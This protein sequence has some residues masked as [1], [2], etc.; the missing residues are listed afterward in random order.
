MHLSADVLFSKLQTDLG[1]KID[2]GLPGWSIDSTVE[3]VCCYSLLGSLLKKFVEG[4]SPAP[5]ACASALDKFLAVNK[6]CA[7]W[8]LQLEFTKDAEVL[9]LIKQELEDFWYADGC[10]PLIEDIRACFFD[11]R[12]G[13]GASIKA[14][15][16]DFYTK[17]FSGPLSA[18]SGLPE[19][20]ERCVTADDRFFLA[21]ARRASI[22]GTTVVASSNYSFVNKTTTIAR[23]ICTEP[24]INM[25]MQ[26]GA[27][28]ILERRLKSF[29]GIDLAKQPDLNRRLAQRGSVDGSVSTIDLESASDSLGLKMLRTILPKGM[30]D[31]LC[32]FRCPKTKLPTG[33]ELV[34]NM[35]STMGNGYT[36]PL[37]TVVFSSV[38]RAVARWHGVRLTRDTF[39]VFGDDIICPTEISRDVIRALNMLGF[40]V[41]HSKSFVEGPFRESCGADWFRGVNVRGVYIKRLNSVQD[42]YVAI[43]SLNLWSARTG[44]ALNHTVTYLYESLRGKSEV[45]LDE[46]FDTGVWVP[47]AYRTRK[48]TAAKG[49]LQAY[50]AWK[51]EPDRFYITDGY[52]WTFKHQ[53]MRDY[54]PCGLLLAL[55]G[56]YIRG[57]KVSVRRRKTL[58]V[59]KRLTTPCWDR[60]VPAE[61]SDPRGSVSLRQFVSAWHWNLLGSSALP[62]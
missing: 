18:T 6:R 12:A 34:L 49:R 10:T 38:V 19:I 14:L 15:G 45:P 2:T 36:F 62:G 56:G 51:A 58:Y 55:L 8:E 23:G 4:D 54:N 3:E 7:E 53:R 25:W 47:N 27:G 24:S 41:N 5:Q 52:C 60:W 28:A 44:V 29:F 37:Q 43:N 57:Y 59:K 17:M 46:G 35:I 22:Y 13:P 21:E 32:I 40:V 31:I 20:W 11:G 16:T 39:G 1:Y 9:G 61:V 30:M 48:V 50:V 33:S 26:L 42:T